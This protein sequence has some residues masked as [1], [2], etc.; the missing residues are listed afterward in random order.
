MTRPTSPPPPPS[1]ASTTSSGGWA[2]PAPSPASSPSAFGFDARG[3][4]RTR[5]RAGATGSATCSQ[6]GR[7]R[8]MVSGAL[9]PDS[10]IAEHVR[11]HGDGIRDI[12]FLV[13]DV[14]AAYDAA[15][16]R[17]RHRRCASPPRTRTPHGVIHHAAIR[18]LRRH[19]AHVPRPV[20][21]HGPVRARVRADRPACARSGPDV[22]HHAVRPRRRQRRAGPPRRV[23]RAT[24]SRCSGFDQLTHFDDEQISTEYSALMS[25]VVWNHDKVVLPINEPAE[26]RTQEPDRG[27]PRLLRHARRAAHRAAHRPTS[28]RRCGRCAAR[29]VRFMDVPAEYYDE[30]RARLDGIE[31][32]WEALAELGILVD[33]DHDGLPAP[34]LHR[35]AHRPAHRV[36]RD[37][38]ARG[39]H[40]ASARATSRRS[41]SPSSEPRRAEATSSHGR[42]AAVGARGHAAARPTSACRPA[43][44]RRSTGG[45]GS[46]GRPATS[47]AC[48][49]PTDWIAV[50]GPAAHHAYDTRRLA[51]ADDDL[52]PTLLLGNDQVSIGVAPL[53]ARVDPSS[54][55]TPTATSCSSSTPAPAGCAPSTARSTT[56]PATTSSSP[57]AP[58]TASSPPRPPICSSSRPTSRA[59]S[60]PDKGLLGR[61]ALFDPAMHRGARGRGG[62]RGRRVHRRREAARART[63]VSPTRS[64]RATSS[65]GRA[66][67]RRCGSTSRTSGRS[68]R[69][70]TTCRRRPTPPS[71]PT[72]SSCARSRRARSRRIPT[73]SG[74]RSSTAT[75]TTTR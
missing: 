74:C 36:L 48:H 71:W 75:S 35:D 16:A 43:R 47:T 4:R 13:D 25:T 3:L 60:C 11:T 70:A 62:R 2:T 45:P 8:F 27:V 31:L 32:P 53:R 22:G 18:G 57:A 15:L 38:P 41:S 34:D 21:L 51:R 73:R 39:R 64:T 23:G 66:T 65:A 55:A 9:H 68:R 37:H 63:H 49:A 61:H 1:A 28:S 26:G 44:S 33:R 29:G 67:S 7:V 50:E 46:S 58:R 30:A 12:C 17:G 40:R 59:S 69:P 20:G 19:R 6:Q 10:P 54:S 24:T 42:R 56:A 14:A 72:G 52:W 5:D